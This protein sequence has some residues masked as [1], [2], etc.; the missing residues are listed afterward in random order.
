M[1]G[2][3]AFKE[4][5]LQITHW[6]RERGI[7]ILCVQETKRNANNIYSMFGHTFIFSSFLLHP[8]IQTPLLLR[9]VDNMAWP[10]FVGTSLK[11][12]V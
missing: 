1:K 9:N 12:P 6:M 7:D 5:E 10:S 11:D 3:G 2:I 4:S 8:T